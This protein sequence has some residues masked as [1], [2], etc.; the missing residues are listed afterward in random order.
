MKVRPR[1][2]GYRIVLVAKA[3]APGHR[4]RAKHVSF[5]VARG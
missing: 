3:S 2:R 1:Y 5:G 4:P